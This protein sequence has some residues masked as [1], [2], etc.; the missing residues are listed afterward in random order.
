[1]LEEYKNRYSIWKNA[2]KTLGEELKKIIGC[3]VEVEGLDKN[4]FTVWKKNNDVSY[5]ELLIFDG[6]TIQRKNRFYISCGEGDKDLL[7]KIIDN[8]DKIAELLEIFYFY[9]MVFHK[10][11]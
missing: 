10:K 3:D 5:T 4:R 7:K 6:K 2:D 8:K 11:D 9:Y 1:M